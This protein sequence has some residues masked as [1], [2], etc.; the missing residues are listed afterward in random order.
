[1]DY[2]FKIVA[3][4]ASMLTVAT[5]FISIRKFFLEMSVSKR[6][7]LRDDYEALLLA[8]DN[9][10]EDDKN[11]GNIFDLAETKKYQL[12]VGIPKIDRRKAQYLLKQAE[13][14]LKIDQYKRGSSMVEFSVIED[15]FNYIHGFQTGWIREIKKWGS[16]FLYVIFFILAALP[17]FFWRFFDPDQAKYTRYVTQNS[18]E[19]FWVML[20][21][22]ILMFL[23]FALVSL[24]YS[25][26]IYFAEKLVENKIDKK[27]LILRI[28]QKIKSFFIQ[29]R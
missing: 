9:T 27:A 29:K 12:I 10:S 21:S 13:K 8:L 26:K 16:L 5:A 22:Y 2:F 1:M 15:K 19:S 11:K 7:Q 28:K 3:F 23:F 17:V 24:N 25:A 18:V 14:S 20:I 6:K 4:I